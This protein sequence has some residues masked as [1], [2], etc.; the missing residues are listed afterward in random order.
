MRWMMG[1]TG[2]VMVW[3]GVALSAAPGGHLRYA[4]MTDPQVNAVLQKAAKV[5]D[6]GDRLQLVTEPFLGTPYIL[7]NMGEGPNGDGRDT[8]PRYN[9]LSTDCTTFVEHALAFALSPDVAAAK[10]RL[11]AIRYTKGVVGYG[12]RRHWPDA[13]WVPG[14]IAEGYAVDATA[15][16]AGP[17]GRVE[18]TSVTITPETFQASAHAAG[19]ALTPQEIPNGTFTIPYIPLDDLASHQ[20]RLET[21]LIINIVKAP[22]DG[23]L[24]RISHQGL[25]VRK[26]GK[27]FVRNATSVGP[28]AVV[29]EPL[30][31]FVARQ[32]AAKAWPT[33]GFH[34]MKPT[35]PPQG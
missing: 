27:V 7:G 12:T 32:K 11:D 14:L 9:V 2:G 1:T 22:K 13:Q 30:A 6:L 16:V 10:T 25:V 21:G 34:F 24:V 8:D 15:A 4:E 26:G 18:T 29:D 23:L 19:M 35:V 17:K 31:A 33:V 20:A 3:L 5:P 28:K